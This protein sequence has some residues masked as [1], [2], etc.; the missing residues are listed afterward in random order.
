MHARESWWLTGIALGLAVLAVAA[1]P[2]VA[3]EPGPV[4]V[5]EEPLVIP[6][7]LTGEPEALPMFYQ[8]RAYQGAQG[9][10]YPY[11]LLDE[12]TDVKQ[13]KTYR[14]LYLENEYLKVCVLPELGGRLFYVLDK[15]NN[16][17]LFYHQHVIKPAL[18]GMLGAWISGGVEW[19]AIHHHRATS[20]QPVDST[21][22][23]NADGSKTI[24][25]GETELR[26]RMRWEIGL[27]LFPG[28][29]YLQSTVRIVNRTPYAQSFLYWANAAVGAGPGA[30]VIFPP[31]VE[32][33]T[34]HSKNQFSHWPISHERYSGSDYTAG[35]DVSWIK[36]D[37]HWN[38]FFAWNCQED[39]LGAYDHERD[40]GVVAIADHN[41]LPGKKLWTWGNDEHAKMWERILTDADGPYAE[42]M[43]GGYSDN[44]PD[45]SWLQ[46]YESRVFSHYWYP[47]AKIG[48][49]KNANLEAAVN[50]EI[51]DGNRAKVGVN[52]SSE[53]KGVQ[54]VLAAGKAIWKEKADISPAAPFTK[55]VPLP[56]GATADSLRLSVLDANG[57]EMISFQPLPKKDANSPLPPVVKPPQA[58]KDIATVE[59]LYLT[60][61]RIEQFHS[62]AAEPYPYYE[63]ALKRD[64]GNSQVNTALGVLYC[65]RGMYAKAKDCLDLAV[66]RV[67]KDY[68][69]PRD[70]EALY[71]L[72]V[73]LRGLG[74]N[75]AASA[76][77]QRAAWSQAWTSAACYSLA[78]L[79]WEPGEALGLLNRSL[80][81]N[82]LNGKAVDLK[83]AI[84][85]RT[86]RLEEAQRLAEAQLRQDPLDFWAGNE[87]Y[88]IQAAEKSPAAADT[89]AA[90]TTRMRNATP[91]YLEL[92]VDYGNAGFRKEAR[93]VLD[94][95]IAAGGK[96]ADPILGYYLA[97]CRNMKI[98]DGLGRPV[99]KVAAQASAA[100]TFPFQLE[101]IPILQ[102]AA[103]ENSGDAQAPYL[104]GNLLYDIQPEE[105]VKAWEE[106]ARR[107]DGFYAVHRNLGLGYARQAKDAAKAIAEYEKAI[108]CN[109]NEPKLYYE[110]DQLYEAA[111]TQPQKRLA[112]MQAH[113]DVVSRRD[114]T[115]EQEIKLLTVLGQ[116]DKALELLA[117][118]HFRLWEGSREINVVSIDVHLSKGLALLR[119]G[120]PTEALK[121]FQTTLQPPAN[122]DVY[123]VG[124]RAGQIRYC[125]GLAYQ[126]L[127]DKE[128]AKAAFEKVSVGASAGG[129]GRRG[130]SPEARAFVGLALE[131]MGQDQQAGEAFA[132]VIKSEEDRLKA[133]ED[134]DFF[135]KFGGRQSAAARQADAHYLLGLGYLGQG[136]R[137]KA[138]AQ[139]EQA[140]TLNQAHLW[141]KYQLSALT[142]SPAAAKP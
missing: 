126:A 118:R 16:H 14:A 74:D 105:A 33:A 92:A 18:I 40:A 43:I 25:V 68:V 19:C 84:L 9:R 100:F 8:G 112:M 142:A 95:V 110:L 34:Y 2:A 90:L 89:L 27:T 108:A 67:A 111:N 140:L 58:P 39:F 97:Y 24:W 137:V 7:Y 135:A 131:A 38:S 79:S 106:S 133:G 119:E 6:T 85:R 102:E 116:V 83:A 52:T 53:R 88:L 109:P 124:D 98:H 56:P 104:L 132:A 1:A 63:E 10:V 42:A 17:D 41:I 57:K 60:G 22:S 61:Q 35:V 107:D 113:Q 65:K 12:L 36:N 64:P 72:G 127:G 87:L 46:P 51:T 123:E 120:N 31:S 47:L 128:K 59:E 115:T 26:Q 73:A 66:A 75:G 23:E 5:W 134:E 77:F 62:A 11:R 114:D 32:M 122:V 28:K 93:D 15:T 96:D 139:F 129:S 48:G 4:K 103:E 54:I 121:E 78:E 3:A 138:G 99:K 136:D 94:R 76:A 44:Q 101:A 80:A 50:L 21:L 49:V 69:H 13:D 130:E 125:I 91:S 55:D 29:S 20:F 81:M 117:S 86:G 45:Y 71:Y 82:A 37:P 70:G 30:Q 141:A